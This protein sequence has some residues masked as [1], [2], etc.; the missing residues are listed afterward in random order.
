MK[1]L[2]PDLFAIRGWLGLVHLLVEGREVVV[3]DAGFI[4]DFR[5]IQKE[6]E[7]LGHKSS[8]LKAILLTH[9][10]LDHTLNAERLKQW[11]GAKIYAPA[12]DELHVAGRYPY[13]GV[14]RICGWLEACGRPLLRYRPPS[15]DVWMRDGDELPFWGG[16]RVVALPGHTPGHVGFYSPSKRVFFVGDGFANSWRIALPPP[17]FNTDSQEMRRSLCKLRQ[18]DVDW[19]VP[20]HYFR[21]DQTVVKRVRDKA[22]QVEKG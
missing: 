16:L 8:D 7:A 6:L 2:R 18:F 15:I 13:R 20:A 19:F 1:Q 11:S 12:G 4:G 9:G 5:R 14:A 22:E 10:H 3:T 21:L 17:I